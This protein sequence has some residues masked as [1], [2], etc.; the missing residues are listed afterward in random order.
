MGEGVARLATHAGTLMAA[1]KVSKV[2]SNGRRGHEGG[3]KYVELS[4]VCC[5]EE[6]ETEMEKEKKEE[7]D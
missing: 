4:C 3:C 7:E 5:V 1:G 6:E 2:T